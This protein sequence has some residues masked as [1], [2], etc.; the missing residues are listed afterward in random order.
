MKKIKLGFTDTHDHLAAFFNHVLSMR[1]DVEI[2]KDAEPD[3]LIFGDRNFGTD[4][5][6]F[7]KDKVT[8]I[9]YTGENQRPE[10]YECHSLVQSPIQG[11][12]KT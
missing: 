3:F 6:N 2:V 12:A 5:L 9:F 4:N 1:Y 11:A 8:K 7:D 10:D